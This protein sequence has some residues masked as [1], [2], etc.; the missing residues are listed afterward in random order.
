MN[1]YLLL[2]ALPLLVVYACSSYTSEQQA[3]LDRGEEVYISHCVS[4]HGIHGDGMQGAYPSLIKPEIIQLHTDRTIKLIREGSGFEG[5]M[6]PISLTDAELIEVV[7]Y[8]QNTW[9]NQAEFIAEI[10]NQ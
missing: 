7:N 2:I 3:M 1:K 5:G 9:G 6:K 4:C 8:I 10:S